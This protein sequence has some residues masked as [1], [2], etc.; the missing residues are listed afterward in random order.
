MASNV[1]YMVRERGGR[2]GRKVWHEYVEV[3]PTARTT[4]RVQA[5]LKPRKVMHRIYWRGSASYEAPHGETS[6]Q[7]LVRAMESMADSG[8]QPWYPKWMQIDEGI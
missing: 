8:Y 6:D 7:W 4:Y 1:V 5:K 3:D 2:H